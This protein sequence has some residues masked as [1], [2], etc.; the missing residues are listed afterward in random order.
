MGRAYR[1]GKGVPQDL[2][3]AIK[4]YRWA[5][6][7]DPVWLSELC[8][9]L[10]KSDKEEYHKM[11]LEICLERCNRSARYAYG[12][13]GRI[14]R[15]GKGVEKDLHAAAAWYRKAVEYGVEWAPLEL[16]DVIWTFDDR[17]EDLDLLGLI[18]PLAEGGSVAAMGRLGR[19]YHRGRGVPKDYLLARRWLRRAVDRD[20]AWFQ[21]LYQTLLDSG[22]PRFRDE[23]NKLFASESERGSKHA[24]LQKARMYRDGK[25]VEKNIW[26]AEEWYRKA[27]ECDMP[28]A[29]IEL[30][31]IYWYNKA[32]DT[33]KEMVN[34][35]LPFADAGNP[36]AMGR[37]GRA[38]RYGRGVPKNLAMAERWTA[39]ACEKDPGRWSKGL[40]AIR[41]ERK[42]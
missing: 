21:E 15:D 1:D 35:I 26:A 38:Y 10:L 7:K 27:I 13:L 20:S 4:W 16:F 11:C 2:D 18:R 39:K 5:Y 12:F 31:E 29:A 3:E 28:I 34:I 6:E 23:A 9:L 25:G 17:K 36:G 14:Y 30:F 33:D 42:S 8:E 40:E 22:D 24:Y 37:L 19:M 41:S 32:E